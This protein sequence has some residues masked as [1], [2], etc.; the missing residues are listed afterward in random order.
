MT[1]GTYVSLHYRCMLTHHHHRYCRNNRYCTN[2]LAGL[3]IAPDSQSHAAAIVLSTAFSCCCS[4]TFHS[5]NCSLV[6][7]QLYFPQQ[8]VCIAFSPSGVRA[9]Q[10][11]T[12]GQPG[13]APAIAEPY[14]EEAFSFTRHHCLQ[15]EVPPSPLL[16]QLSMM[17]HH[18]TCHASHLT[19]TAPC[20]VCFNH[21]VSPRM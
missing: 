7:L 10:R 4:C 12:Q 15:R 1:C 2:T 19:S 21:F 14:S 20:L 6:L 5:M 3:S 17:P 9:P 11:A 18:V 16:L 8:G 13:R